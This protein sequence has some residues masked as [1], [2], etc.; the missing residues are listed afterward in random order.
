[1][2]VSL[3]QALGLEDGHIPTFW[4]L[5]QAFGKAG[6]SIVEACK[7]QLVEGCRGQPVW[8]FARLQE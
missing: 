8:S 5:L 1:M 3:L 6:M 7:L 4:L 2:M